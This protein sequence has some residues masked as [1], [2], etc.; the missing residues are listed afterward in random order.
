[1]NVRRPQ[2]SENGFNRAEV[3]V[4]LRIGQETVIALEIGVVSLGIASVGVQ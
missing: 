3:I 2:Y 1:M 4:T